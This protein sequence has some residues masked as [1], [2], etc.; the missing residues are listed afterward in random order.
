MWCAK[1]KFDLQPSI[2]IEDARLSMAKIVGSLLVLV[3]GLVSVVLS[4]G[5]WLLL[6]VTGV[7][8]GGRVDSQLSFD[9]SSGCAKARQAHCTAEGG[10]QLCTELPPA[11]LLIPYGTIY[12]DQL[13]VTT[14][15]KTFEVR[16][17]CEGTV[18]GDIC[19]GATRQRAKEGGLICESAT[20]G[21]RS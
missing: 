21:H 10:A 4:N 16:E 3:Y 12:D 18:V 15:I 11:N 5:Y 8:Q 19:V 6:P 1:L 14:R 17:T 9:P 2:E 20:P 7:S 13:Y